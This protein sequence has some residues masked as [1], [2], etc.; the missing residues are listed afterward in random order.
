MELRPRQEVVGLV[1]PAFVP[2]D[3]GG[4]NHIAERY[5]LYAASDTDED[6]HVCFEMADASVCNCSHSDIARPDFNNGNLPA[7]EGTHEEYGA[8]HD[9]F[10]M[11]A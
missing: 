8:L 2:V 11:I 7:H 4:H 10:V 9:F 3:L 6:R 5:I 1:L